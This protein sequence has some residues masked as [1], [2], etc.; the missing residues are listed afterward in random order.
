MRANKVSLSLVDPREYLSR[1]GG[2]QGLSGYLQHAAGGGHHKR[3]GYALAGG[4]PHHEAQPT[5]GEEVEV[6]EVSSYLSTWPVEWRDL[7]ALYLRH[8]FGER[9]LLDALRHPKLL[10]D[11][12]ALDVQAGQKAH[13]RLGIVSLTV[14]NL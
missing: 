12:V 6:V 14:P 3:C 7:P 9:G 4:I 5:L 2:V 13:Q 8:R 10:L 1:R 11:A